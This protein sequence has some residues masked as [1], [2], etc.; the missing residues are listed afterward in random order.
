[1]GA[2]L[3]GEQASI[4]RSARTFRE[5]QHRNSAVPDR[6]LR[7]PK[8]P[9]RRGITR[10]VD[11]DVSGSNVE[12]AEEGDRAELL[13]ADHHRALGIEFGE[14]GNVEDALVVRDVHA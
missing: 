13:L 14:D 3:E 10:A 5:D 11:E 12:P 1:E 8:P 9:H 4:T 6:A 7:F 2:L